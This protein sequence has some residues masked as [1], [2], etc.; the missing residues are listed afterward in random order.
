MNLFRLLLK[1]PVCG[2]MQVYR[3][4]KMDVPPSAAGWLESNDWLHEDVQFPNM[5]C[6]GLAQTC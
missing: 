4:C 1:R 6:L 3:I 2:W 5:S